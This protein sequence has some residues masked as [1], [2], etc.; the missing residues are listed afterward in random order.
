MFVQEKVVT[1]GDGLVVSSVETI[2][3]I[4]VAPPTPAPVQAQPQPEADIN[5]N[6]VTEVKQEVPVVQEAPKPVVAAPVVAQP[7]PV[8]A[9]APPAAAPFV[10]PS[11][12]FVPTPFVAAA[13][14]QAPVVQKPVDNSVDY[15]SQTV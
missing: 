6:I 2:E 12:M 14:A 8:V 13:Q 7:A 1:T 9:Q 15:P 4:V 10:A 5:N 3:P 11:P